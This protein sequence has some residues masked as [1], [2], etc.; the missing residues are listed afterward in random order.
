MFMDKLHYIMLL[1]NKNINFV[2]Y[3][4]S[5]DCNKEIIEKNGR[6][7]LHYACL[8]RN[9]PVVKYLIENHCDQNIKDIYDK[10]PLDYAN[11]KNISLE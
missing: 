11:D 1:K 7:P 4:I 10:T 2:K 9:I 8:I 3:L 6:T 5:K